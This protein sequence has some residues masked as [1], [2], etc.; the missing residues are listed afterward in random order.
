MR[1]LDLGAHDGYLSLGIQQRFPEAHI[2]AIELNEQAA[3]ACNARISGECKVGA[4]EDAYSLFETQS[5]DVVVA[6]ELIEHVPNIPLFLAACEQMVKPGGLIYIS[7]PD[8]CF[9]TGNNPHHLRALRAI[10]L[11]DMLRRRGT[12]HDMTVGS[13]GVTVAAYIPGPRREDI[14]I[15]AGPGWE[16]WHP[17]DIAQR[18]LGGSE[19]AA[20]RLSEALSRLGF[21][22]TVYGEM[23][24]DT[25]WADVIYRHHSK[26]D[27]LDARGAVISSRMPHV[28]D[29]PISAPTRMLWVHD[30]DCGDQLTPARAEGIDHVLALSP[31]HQGHLKGR[32]PFVADKV[33]LARN[34]I[35]HK[36]FDP[37]P[38]DARAKRVLYTSSPDRGLDILLE[39]WPQILEAVPD[40]ELHHCYADVY[41]KIA[42]Q[43]PSVAKHRDKIR[44][45]SDQPGV[46]RLGSL[47][48]PKLAALMCQSRVWAHPS[49]ATMLDQPFHET[50]CISAMEAQAAG[51]L[52]VASDWGALHDTVRWGRKVNS[53]PPGKRWR[54]AM[55]NSIIEG[56]TNPDV[57]QTA[58]IEAPAA[59]ADLSWDGVAVQLGKLVAAEDKARR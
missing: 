48:Q 39:I 32:Y 42:D 10:D 16:P 57:G 7:T 14:A 28:F 8:G 20:I 34:G 4:A 50:S 37:L 24:E 59:V 38:W 9:G 17:S 13:D 12:L 35:E 44:E 33:R 21:V 6:F 1:I 27:P 53:D 5:Y 46:V 29:R 30:V 56:L 54:K 3:A 55:V 49:W 22:V 52:V 31:W 58:V 45:L 36:L 40:A 47:P 11:A 19:T 43:D 51:C 18:G 26:F 2:D 41:D 23:R 15:Y 25:C